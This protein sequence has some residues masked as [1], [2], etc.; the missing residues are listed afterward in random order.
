MNDYSLGSSLGFGLGLRFPHFEEI[1]NT[2]PQ[3]DWFEVISEN[4]ISAH[5]G[6]IEY[7]SDL[8]KDYKL[9]MHGVG[10]S[11]GSTDALDLK[12][13][14]KIKNL[15]DRLSVSIVSDHLCFTGTNGYKTHDLLPI[16]YTEEALKHI[17][18][19]I[20][21]VQEIMGKEF[22][23]ENAST[24]IEFSK[25]DI[26]EPDFLNEICAKTGCKILLDVNNVFVSSFNNG[27]NTKAYIDKIKASNVVQ[28]HLAGFLHKGSHIIDTHDNFVA[29]EVWDLFSYT[30]KTKGFKNTMIEWDDNIPAFQ[31]LL[32]ELN[33]AKEVVAKN[34]K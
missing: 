20:H 3:V 31:E 6:Y 10:L 24:Y 7:L 26:P 28:Y 13:L 11:I 4:Y 19:R 27:W 29:Q 2:K 33:K 30:I 8:R 5:N 15:S 22:V 17:I 34:G 18:P 14:A 12:Y 16:P 32:N 1:I 21:K 9:V 25:S 23:F